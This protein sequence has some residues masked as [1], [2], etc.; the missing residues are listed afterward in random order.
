MRR[1]NESDRKPEMRWAAKQIPRSR[2]I[3]GR[4]GLLLNVPSATASGETTGLRCSIWPASG[5]EQVSALSA[6][7]TSGD[8]LGPDPILQQP[9]RAKNHP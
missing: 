4:C 1:S 8:R 7:S 6:G 3:F 2:M 5:E 9:V